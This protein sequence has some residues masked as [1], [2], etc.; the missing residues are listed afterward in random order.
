MPKHTRNGMEFEVH[1]KELLII[2]YWWSVGL[3]AHAPD[4][5]LKHPLWPDNNDV[6]HGEGGM[7]GGRFATPCPGR[8]RLWEAIDAEFGLGI[9]KKT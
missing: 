4:W 9:N 6:Y 8:D 2:A 1:E 5:V 7:L 3:R